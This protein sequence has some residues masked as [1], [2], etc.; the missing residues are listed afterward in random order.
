MAI[1]NYSKCRYTAQTVAPSYRYLTVDND[2][3]HNLVENYFANGVL[4]GVQCQEV[5]NITNMK[6]LI[7]LFL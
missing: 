3:L 2:H 1:I 4:S 5:Y 7:L 6:F